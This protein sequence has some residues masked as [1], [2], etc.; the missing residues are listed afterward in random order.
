V[1]CGGKQSLK[2]SGSTAQANA[3][4]LFVTAYQKACP[5]QTL[6]YTSNGSGAG[7]SE[8]LGNQPDFGGSDSPLSQQRGEYAAAK[9]RCGS[10]AWN[11]PSCSGPW[12]SPTTSA[13]STI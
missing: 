10:D 11:L 3:M 12:R 4:P 7:V 13:R 1:D 8:F 9:A 2:A 6:T 5:G